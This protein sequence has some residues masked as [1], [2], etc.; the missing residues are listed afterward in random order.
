MGR[1]S[2][3]AIAF[4]SLSYLL[5][6]VGQAPP[7][8]ASPSADAVSR[9]DKV[10]FKSGAN[11]VEVPVV[12]RDATGHA[13]G[14]LSATD[15]QLSDNG[16]PQLISR[17]T[18]EN[19]EGRETLKTQTG[20]IPYPSGGDVASGALP[21]RFVAFL[22]DDINLG[23]ANLSD[24][25]ALARERS[26]TIGH[27]EDL[28]PADRAAVYSFSGSVALDFTDDRDQLRKAILGVPQRPFQYMRGPGNY[29][30]ADRIANGRDM[31]ASLA[32]RPTGDPNR[33]GYQMSLE[34][35]LRMEAQR[36][37]NVY[38]G[39]ADS[40]FRVLTNLIA[41]MST[42]TGPRSIVLISAGEYVADKFRQRVSDIVADAIRARVVV[43]AV[44][45]GAYTRVPLPDPFLDNL[46][47][48]TGGVYAPPT[49]NG[50]DAEQQLRRAD[51]LPEYVY[52]LGFS[53]SELKLDSTFHALE[54]RL[55]NS[56]GL[57][58][59]TRTGYFATGYGPDLVERS[60]DGGQPLET[61]LLD[62]MNAHDVRFSADV[63]KIPPQIPG[64][65][66]GALNIRVNIDTRTLSLSKDSGET[67][68]KEAG[69]V[70]ELFIELNDRGRWLAKISDTKSFEFAAASRERYNSEGIEWPISIPLAPGTVKLVIILR[71]TN[72]ARV[73][74][75]TVPLSST[76]PVVS[77]IGPAKKPIP[78][79][80]DYPSEL[81]LASPRGS[82]EPHEDDPVIEGARK[83]AIAFGAS[84]PDYI[85]K[86]TTTR[87]GGERSLD[88]RA[89]ANT[90]DRDVAWYEHDTVTAEVVAEHG[91]EVFTK[92]KV[93][94][95]PSNNPE[96]S[97]FWSKG[98]FSSALQ[99]VLAVKSAASF[100]NKREV[101]IAQRASYRYDFAIDQPHSSW[102]INARG[103][104]EITSYAPA[105]NGAI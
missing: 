16:K 39:E 82:T 3:L 76:A 84:L 29:E 11:L 100:T 77:V 74:S 28:R 32:G 69:T 46:T 90:A 23:A 73:G 85:V 54:V 99:E 9:D 40:F 42:M 30:S 6:C 21:G 13:V 43:N 65:L 78:V 20:I 70:D 72:A 26:A 53:P 36:R 5:P 58:L 18:I 68:T 62:Q 104:N 60:E 4:L 64:D 47:S 56:R 63:K 93:N 55:K 105:Y 14:G 89:W 17:F 103:W 38:D 51:S 96:D 57:T 1:N 97:G 49:G 91:T 44:D 12:I 88:Q 37:L 27:L 66:T 15:F 67:N 19:L 94:G 86:R 33:D 2:T 95:K 25:D 98:E 81:V 22:L 80:S 92:V 31:A 83:S 52:V 10:V 71:D 61:V 79:G 45:P 75:L 7:S 59:R 102:Q 50:Y 101:T 87:F 24:V 41:K 34:E 8:S 35:S 48:G